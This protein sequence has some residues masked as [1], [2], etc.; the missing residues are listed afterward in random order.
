MALAGE[1]DVAPGLAQRVGVDLEL[2][3]R[4]R[5]G[6]NAQAAPVAEHGDQQA[7]GGDPQHAVR[8]AGEQA[9]GQGADQDGDEG[10][11]LDQRVAADQLV[12]VEVL[13]QDG[14]LH[15]AEQ[16][17][18]QAE[19]EQRGEQQ[20]EAVCPEAGTG[21]QHD[22]DLQQLGP[23]RQH[24]L[25][26]L[27]GELAGG[28]REQKERQDEQARRQ[29]GQHADAERRP[30]RGLEGQQHHQR[31]LEQV[32]VERA[33]ELGGE[34]RAE[35]ARLEQVEGRTHVGLSWLASAARA[36]RSAPASARRLRAT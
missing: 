14:V 19:Q 1:A 32:V 26:V 21:D 22:D 7:A 2:R 25:V 31:V 17:R 30:L 12:L 15:R 27:V 33:E 20:F 35:A 4:R 5:G 3:L 8:G 9:A 11:G 36:G 24:G 13:R 28:G 18:L 6:G 10:A 16:G 29:V 23:A 34:Q